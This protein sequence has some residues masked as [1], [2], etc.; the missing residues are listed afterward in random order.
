MC[1]LAWSILLCTAEKFVDA[2]AIQRSDHFNSNATATTTLRSAVGLPATP[3]A[4]MV[5]KRPAADP[6]P[7]APREPLPALPS[8]SAAGIVPRA[9]AE[10]PSPRTSLVTASGRAQQRVVRAVRRALQQ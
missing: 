7:G 8:A 3:S 10:V 2:A 4:A 1:R 5:R 6:V 9:E